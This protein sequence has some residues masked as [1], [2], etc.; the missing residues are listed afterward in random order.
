MDDDG[1]ENKENNSTLPIKKCPVYSLDAG[2][3]PGRILTNPK[4]VFLKADNSH[5]LKIQIPNR[6]IRQDHFKCF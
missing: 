2:D 1:R 4:S 3:R 6:D 5:Q